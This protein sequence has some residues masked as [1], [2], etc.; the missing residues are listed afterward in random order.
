MKSWYAAR[1]RPRTVSSALPDG[2]FVDFL[3]YDKVT[4]R[5]VLVIE[6]DGMSFHAEGSEQWKRDRLKD[7]ILE[8]SGVRCLRLP[9]NGSRE[10]E[11]IVE[12]LEKRE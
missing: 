5:P 11:R 8:K 9:T 2:V 1:L 10:R 3:V 7:S 6:A 12:A 4:R